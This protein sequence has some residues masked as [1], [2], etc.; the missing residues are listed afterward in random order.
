[1]FR[2]WIIRSLFLVP[3]LCVV[4]VWVASYFGGLCLYKQ[5]GRFLAQVGTLPGLCYVERNR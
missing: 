4:A 1:M 3:L 2:R 5:F